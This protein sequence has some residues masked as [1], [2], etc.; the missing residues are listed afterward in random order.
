[1]DFLRLALD[2][3]DFLQFSGWL[4]TSSPNSS[5]LLSVLVVG[6]KF[7][8]AIDFKIWRRHLTYDK[9]LEDKT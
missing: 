5:W 9:W 2:Y 8:T 4:Q 1:M 3:L 7:T 6:N